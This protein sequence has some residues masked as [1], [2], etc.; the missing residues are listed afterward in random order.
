MVICLAFIAVEL[1]AQELFH[2]KFDHYDNRSGLGSINVRK[3]IQDSFGF[4]WIATQDGLYRFDGK[5]FVNYNKAQPE[6]HSITGPDI[7]DVIE[8]KGMIWVITSFGGINAIDSRSSNVVFGLAQESDQELSKV[9]FTSLAARGD[10]LFIGSDK[11]I[12]YLQVNDRKLKP[13]VLN[14]P[15]F[16][17]KQSPNVNRII[18]DKEKRLWA[19]CQSQGVFAIDVPTSKVI[20]SL[21][22]PSAI[23]FD[24]AIWGNSIVAGT[25]EGLRHY[26]LSAG[27]I[28]SNY[29]RF[30]FATEHMR[31]PVFSVRADQ[32]D[33]LWFSTRRHLIK[34]DAY[35]KRFWYVK[36]SKVIEKDWTSSVYAIFFD[37]MN[38]LWLGCHEGVSFSTNRSAAFLAYHKSEETKE[39]ISHAYYIYPNGDSIT[40]V[41][42]SDALYKVNRLTGEIGSL[43]KGKSYYYVFEDANHR[44]IA[45]CDDGLV[46][47]GQKGV[48]PV[49]EVYPEFKEYSSLIVNSHLS[50]DKDRLMFGSQDRRGVFV[51]DRERHSIANYSTSVGSLRLKDD[52]V[53][54]L[55]KDRKGLIWILTNNSISVMDAQLG[56]VQHLEVTDPRLKKAYSLFYDVCEYGDQYFLATYRDGIVVLDKEFRFVREISTF[57]GL[58]NNSVYKLLLFRDSLL[59]AT[60]NNGL[61]V[62][63]LATSKVKNY[64]D[65]NGLTSS[66]FEELS[67]NSA[68]DKIYVGGKDGFTIIDPLLLRTNDSPP[69]LYFSRIS[70]ES[71]GKA[72]DSS[73]LTST[74]MVVPNDAV[75]TTVY[76]SAL[77]FSNPAFTSFSYRINELSN[78]WTNIGSQHFVRFIGLSPGTYHLSIKAA[79]EDGLWS[80]PREL[81]LVFL[82]KWYQTWWFRSLIALLIIGVLYGIYRYRL[83]QV[84]QEQ[85]MRQRI[86]SD[87]HDDI[88]STLNSVKVFANLAMMKSEQNAPYLLQLKEGVQGAIV[89]IRDMVW[90]LDDKQDTVEHLVNRVEQF[91][92]PVVAAQDIRFEKIM[93]ATVADRILKKEEK[94]NLYLILK[95]A[96]NN[97]I[98]YAEASVLQVQ[99]E[100]VAYDQF[101]I[102]VS[103]N[104]KGFDIATVQ[105]GNG[106]NNLKYRAQ[107]IRYQIDINSVPGIGTTIRL[108]SH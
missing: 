45:S 7:R 92:Y 101:S 30:L 61:S 88:G 48:T 65:A 10:T 70:V 74:K 37:R 55:Y 81:T 19:F 21:D 102:V 13:Y 47:V 90:I 46:I 99:I 71:P 96:L 12:Y 87:L 79:N 105:K 6:R 34:M 107:Q 80:A 75:Q 54:A 17:I 33:N 5:E 23:Y 64:F 35:S 32:S 52:N 25:N 29:D 51:W 50:I 14:S 57:N 24:G 28:L 83:W 85:Q 108:T 18:F 91:I 43:D 56:H 3:I 31:S 40:L 9:L 100:K 98:K 26:Y 15:A 59:F 106:L 84:K 95:E 89:G 73:D 63:H 2:L 22:E 93:D 39:T 53:N 69:S 41:C 58:A 27:R 44:L 68:G 62:I 82:P 67:G 8:V 76:F 78:E 97:S 49:S 42:A 60:T 66:V 36:E 77:N 38:N 103:D 72:I 94:R 11:G 104:G 20:A 1:R 4:I 86:A 16:Y